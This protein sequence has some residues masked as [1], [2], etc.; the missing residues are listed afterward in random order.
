MELVVRKADLLRELNLL[1]GIVERKVTI[2]VLA[3]VLMEADGN[4]LKLVATDLD[5]AL[6][7]RCDASVS[8][9][10]TLTVPAKRLFDIV[11]AL[12]DTD[13][14]I[15]EDRAGMKIAAERFES[16]MSTVAAEEFPV[17]PAGADTYHETFAAGSLRQMIKKTQFAITGEDT[18]YYLNGGLLVLRPERMT[19]VT[20]DGHRLALVTVPRSAEM[21]ASA[22]DVILPRKTLSEL[23]RILGD[24]DA[25]VQYG[26]GENHL[27]FR[28][29][30]RVLISRV[31]DGQFPAYDRVIPRNNDKLVSFDRDRLM[32]A[33]KRVGILSN[34]RS[35]AVKLQV[36]P[37][38]VEIN[39]STP[40]VGDAREVIQVDY[41]GPAMQLCFNGQY[42]Q[43]FLSAVETEQVTLEFKDDVSQ[44]VMRPVAAEGYEY[45]YVIMPM[46]L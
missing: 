24:G 37:G 6:R 4:E 15:E 45:T 2:A 8:K 25:D 20:T 3:N 39:S 12:P 19:F 41:E 36:E 17:L 11:R 43:D 30:G 10:G 38:Q 31:I 16:R 5:V 21:A 34:E 14:R 29:G 1:Q 18:R 27:F 22:E 33:V 9:A 7:S 44:A 42:I 46:R 28:A 13:I 23:D 26:R 35:R 40:D 32:Q